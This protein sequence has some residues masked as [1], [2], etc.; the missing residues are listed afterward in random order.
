MSGLTHWI[1]LA[2]EFYMPIILGEKRFEVRKDDRLYRVGDYL[3]MTT[4]DADGSPLPNDAKRWV[5]AKI[6]YRL[7]GGSYGIEDGYVVLGI[8]AFAYGSFNDDGTRGQR[9]GGI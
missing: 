9:E 7:Q 2:R 4:V 6:T 1:K 3:E 8:Q 5:S